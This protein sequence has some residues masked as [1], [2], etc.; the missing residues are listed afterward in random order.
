MSNAETA[1]YE[2][3]IDVGGYINFIT[4]L[5]NLFDNLDSFQCL[6][7]ISDKYHLSFY[8]NVESSCSSLKGLSNLTHYFDY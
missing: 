4:D 8:W 6:S 5:I 7:N 1:I 2:A 3:V